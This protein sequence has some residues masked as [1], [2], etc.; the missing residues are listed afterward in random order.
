MW[1]CAVGLTTTSFAQKIG[2]DKS[3][4]FSK[5]RTYTWAQPSTPIMRP[6]LYARVVGAIDEQLAG[7]GL[8]RV[9]ENGDLLLIYS[10]GTELGMNTAAPTPVLSTYIGPPTFNGAMWT[11]AYDNA[12]LTAVYVH[13]GMLVVEF[14]DRSANQV[15]WS[16]SV[17]EKF[18]MEKKSESLKHA[19]KA[20]A[21]LLRRFPPKTASK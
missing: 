15:V 17:K 13:E 19:E 14:V 5:Y 8:K 3:V 20:V 2:Y 1:L 11:G 21:K 9:E 6:I 7:K 16:G 4:D 12:N 10:G 18:S